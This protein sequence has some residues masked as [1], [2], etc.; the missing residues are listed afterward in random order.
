LRDLGVC[1]ICGGPNADCLCVDCGRLVCERCFSEGDLCVECARRGGI[2]ISAPRRPS[3][4][5]VS[6]SGL[7]MAGMLLIIFGLMVTSMAMM[8]EEGEGVI[9]LFPFV[10]GGVSGGMAVLLSFIFLGVFIATSLLPWY[11][12]HRRQREWSGYGA[13]EWD[14]SPRESEAM[15][16]M[17]TIEV[18][19]EL[20]K[21][22]Y[23]EG[24]SGEVRL[25]STID[26]SFSRRYDLPPGFDVDE[27]NYEYE[28]DYLV[29]RLRLKRA[30]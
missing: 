13:A 21:T 1:S 10:F 30:I 18:P 6:S 23:I 5:G 17:I 29:L 14:V 11:M 27:Y 12:L 7:R 15:E 9:V 2:N 19:P 22:V 4:Q 24:A 25:G 3:S 8:P 26:G 28:G 20:R 16:Y